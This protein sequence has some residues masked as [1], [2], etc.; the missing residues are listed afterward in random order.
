ML[1]F[2][3]HFNFGKKWKSYSKIQFTNLSHNFI[4]FRILL[5]KAITRKTQ[6]HK[7]LIL[8]FLPEFFQPVKLSTQTAFCRSIDDENDF[9]FKIFQRN[10]FSFGIF[11]RKIINC[12]HKKFF[13]KYI[14]IIKNFSDFSSFKIFHFFQKTKNLRIVGT[15][16]DND[17][18]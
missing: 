13:K 3:I 4:R 7:I 5:C 16:E 10:F 6:N 12:F 17:N 1:I 14:E 18:K 11:Y 9:I 2:A 15:I 8:I